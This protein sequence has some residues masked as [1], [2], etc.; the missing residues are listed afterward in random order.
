MS[1]QGSGSFVANGGAVRVEEVV[2]AADESG[3]LGGIGQADLVY[4]LYDDELQDVAEVLDLL[5]AG[6]EEVQGS[7]L[8][9]VDQHH[10]RV[11]LS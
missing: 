4:E 2:D 10:E 3:P 7:V 9:G 8:V 11:A 5:N 1:H 6:T